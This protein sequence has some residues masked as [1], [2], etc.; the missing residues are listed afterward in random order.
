MQM[1]NDSDE[2]YKLAVLAALL[3]PELCKTKPDEAMWATE[4]LLIA[5]SRRA[6]WR[7]EQREFLDKKSHESI[8]YSEAVKFIADEWL[9]SSPKLYRAKDRFTKFWAFRNGITEAKA[10][11]Q[12]RDYEQD[13]KHFTRDES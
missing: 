9:T 6:Q 8:S 10:K 2:A 12:V 7:K 4:Q 11:Q 5:A 3:D 1:N 13:K